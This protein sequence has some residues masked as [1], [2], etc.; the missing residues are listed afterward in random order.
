MYTLLWVQRSS[1]VSYKS[2]LYKFLK[3]IYKTRCRIDR[4]IVL[5]FNLTEKYATFFA[6]CSSGSKWCKLLYWNKMRDRTTVGLKSLPY[7]ILNLILL[8]IVDE[9]YLG[10][11]LQYSS[12]NFTVRRLYADHNSSCLYATYAINLDVFSNSFLSCFLSLK[13]MLIILPIAI[14]FQFADYMVS[15]LFGLGLGWLRLL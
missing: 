15:V 4:N 3:I 14:L 10:N 2:R 8:V 6:F 13:L 5:F 11:E 7:S 1:R 12:D 9:I